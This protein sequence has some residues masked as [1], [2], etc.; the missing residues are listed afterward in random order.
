VTAVVGQRPGARLA[1]TRWRVLAREGARTLV[2]LRPETGRSHQLRVAAASLGAPLEGDLKYGADE[3]L[4]DRS[5]ALHAVSLEVDH[6]T[7]GERV[8]IRCAPPE[9]EWWRIAAGR[10]GAGE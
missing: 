10:H 9:R 2:E 4:A 8:T 7:R 6:P 5:I 3:P 1:V